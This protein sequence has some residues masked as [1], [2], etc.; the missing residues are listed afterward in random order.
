MI[1]KHEKLTFY[2]LISIEQITLQETLGTK[3]GNSGPK[4]MKRDVSSNKV[5]VLNGVTVIQS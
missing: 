3:T 5:W 2:I 1:P 4:V